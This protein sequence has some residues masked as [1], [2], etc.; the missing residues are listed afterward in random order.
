MS[1]TM[2]I[3]SIGIVIAGLVLLPILKYYSLSPADSSVRI[4]KEAGSKSEAN[5]KEETLHREREG[6]Q[7]QVKSKFTFQEYQAGMNLLVYG[8]PDMEEAVET[9]QH[10]RS[11]GVNSVAITFPFFQ[12]GWKA[13]HVGTHEQLTPSIDE[14]KEL[15]HE[16]RAADLSIMLRPILDEKNLLASGRWR[17]EIQPADPAAWFDSYRSLLLSYMELAETSGVEV[18][19]IGTELNSLQNRYGDEWIRLIEDIREVFTGELIYSFNWNTVS[20][21][22][23][24]EFVELLDHVGID[25]YFP[26]DA[27]DHPSVEQ[28]EAAWQRWLNELN[29]QLDHESIIITEVGMIPVE[30]AHRQPYAWS[31]PNGKLDWQAQANYYEATYRVLQPI[32]TGLYW[33]C[34][35]LDQSPEEINFSPLDSQTETVIKQ[36]FLR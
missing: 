3:I 17:G 24:V 10:L 18:F 36:H 31:I 9:F 23:D 6:K 2:I 7:Q 13:N 15:I 14:L 12:A 11:L 21:I 16:A 19:N 27:P 26:L 25:A 5:G 32:S 4:A 35:S 22:Q 28:L 1:K 34:V 8:H 29:S 33:W 30:G 20:E